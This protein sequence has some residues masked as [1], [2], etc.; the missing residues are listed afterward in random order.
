MIS[1]YLFN[2]IAD[3]SMREVPEVFNGGFR[4][5]GRKVNNL[6]YADDIVLIATTP[7]ELQE[8]LNRVAHSGGKIW[9]LVINEGKTKVMIIRK[10]IT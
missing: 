8:L 5:G 4:I 1:P 2:I 9:W 6:R 3:M 7:T 10:V